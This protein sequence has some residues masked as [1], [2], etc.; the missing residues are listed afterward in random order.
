MDG[1]VFRFYIGNSRHGEYGVLVGVFINEL[2][3]SGPQ[4]F[5]CRITEAVELVTPAGVKIKNGRHVRD[6]D[7]F[8][9]FMGFIVDP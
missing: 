4:P 2:L 3:S 9:D 8:E 7:G 5:S 1:I 6:A